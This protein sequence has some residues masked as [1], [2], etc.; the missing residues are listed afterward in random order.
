MSV[1][2]IGDNS[3]ETELSEF[4][5]F[6]TF[7]QL[8]EALK[9]KSGGEKLVEQ[10][11]KFRKRVNSRIETGE[12]L[13]IYSDVAGA[14]TQ[15]PELIKKVEELFEEEA[16]TK[17]IDEEL[18]SMKE[19][20]ELMGADPNKRENLLEKAIKLGFNAE[21]FGIVFEKINKEKP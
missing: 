13:N 18:E 15:M 4:D 12:K 10:I 20:E 17:Y 3:G 16:L 19:M 1:E 21:Q 2:K 11:D 9:L 5:S 14:I 6:V 7:D 8:Y